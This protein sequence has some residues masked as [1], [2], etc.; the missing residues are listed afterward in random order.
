MSA[1]LPCEYKGLFL[2]VAKGDKQAFRAIF[3]LYKKPFYSVAFKMTQSSYLAEEI[4]Q[5]VFILFWTKR[6]QVGAA[7]K[8]SNYLFTILYNS[9]YANFKKLASE[10]LMKQA[11]LQQTK[12]WEDPIMEKVLVTREDRQLLDAVIG[13][14][15]PQQQL[16]YKL[17]KQEG[18][19]RLE[20]ASQ[21]HISPHS[22]KNHLHDAVKFIRHHF[23]DKKA[24]S[25]VIFVAAWL[26]L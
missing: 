3:D 20:I 1:S 2:Q 8:P 19:S 22:V 15:P 12:S 17:S 23:K 6:K 26:T 16:V 25:A 7:E 10:K 11:V 18:L 21:M 13:Q 9:V 5:E 4:V 24:V 14:L